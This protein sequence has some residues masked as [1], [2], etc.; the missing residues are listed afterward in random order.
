[1]ANRPDYTGPFGSI[2]APMLVLV[3]LEDPVYAFPIS[4]MAQMAIPNARLAVLP[5]ASHA[6]IFEQPDLANGAIRNW[7]AAIAATR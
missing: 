7:A 2:A 5:G 1:M 3:G 6:V 4:Q